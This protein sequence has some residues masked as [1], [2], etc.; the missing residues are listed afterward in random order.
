MGFVWLFVVGGAVAALLWRLGLPRLVWSMAGAAVMLGATGYA[1]QGRPLLG[2]A[3]R[4]AGERL[5]DVE[6][7][8][9]ELR[10]DLF[11]RYTRESTYLIAADALTRSG[12]TEAAVQVELGGI[13]N[14][15]QSAMLWTGLGDT[16]ARHD[17]DQVSPPAL[18]AFQQAMR[19]APRHPGPPFFLGLAY[20]RA[21]RLAEAAPYWHRALAL[22][23]PAA[24]YRVAIA[25][26]VVLLDTYLRQIGAAR[27]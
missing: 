19:L 7:G 11:G 5:I 13:R 12:D 4:E 9:I 23:P 6:Q 10:G 26:R 21:Q 18:F 22:C 2:G 20:V 15:P 17:G 25:Q 14:D 27:P 16:L 3:P 24:P 1:L 8:L